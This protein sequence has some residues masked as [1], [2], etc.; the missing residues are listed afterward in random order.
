MFFAAAEG[1]S[2]ARENSFAPREK[3]LDG[4]EDSFASREDGFAAAENSFDSRESFFAADENRRMTDGTFSRPILIYF[5]D[6]LRL[7][8][9]HSIWQL[10]ALVFPP[11]CQGLM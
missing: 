4:G 8:S 2:D 1:F 3:G 7:S 11:S 6:F 10:A 5:P 9:L